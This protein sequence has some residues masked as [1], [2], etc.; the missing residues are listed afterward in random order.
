MTSISI[1]T[2]VP[3]SHVGRKLELP[4]NVDETRKQM[5]PFKV[6]EEKDEENQEVNKE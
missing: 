1:K 5:L 6:Q 3:T 4:F 2:Q